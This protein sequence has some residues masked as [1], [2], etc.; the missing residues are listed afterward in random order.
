MLQSVSRVGV[1]QDKPG[2][3]YKSQVVTC[4]GP[5]RAPRCQDVE[6]GSQCFLRWNTDDIICFCED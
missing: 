5:G 4:R 1:K 6:K 2:G 3:R